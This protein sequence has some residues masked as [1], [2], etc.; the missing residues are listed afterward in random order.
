MHGT[1]L[2]GGFSD[3]PRQSA[4]A[5]RAALTALSR[6]GIIVEVDGA[7]PPA[8]LSVAAGVLLLADL[9]LPNFGLQSMVVRPAAAAHIVRHKG[10]GI[11]RQE[12]A[13][14]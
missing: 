2:E 10:I 1:A 14:R 13:R 9:A 6:P 8:P 5:F 4:R 12:E 3:A 11:C 7:A